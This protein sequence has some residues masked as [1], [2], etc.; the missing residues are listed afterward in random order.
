MPIGSILD[1]INA[2]KVRLYLGPVASGNDYV[3]LQEITMPLS[4]AETREAVAL[5]SVYFYG[6]HDNSFDATFLLTGG[7]IGT[8][9][10][11]NQI[12]NGHLVEL[13]YDL[14][15]IAKDGTTTV[16]R[17]TAVAPEQEIEKLPEG[18]VKI[19]QT[20]RITEDVDSGNIV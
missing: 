19:Y 20:F 13:S 5:G 17:V 6:Q 8:F 2:R 1:V 16:I 14:Q 3:D 10:N 4:R 9:L 11:R 18:G 12:V 7:D 15:L